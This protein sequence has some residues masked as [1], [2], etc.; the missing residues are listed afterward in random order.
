MPEHK[1]YL[2]PF[3]GSGAVFFNKEPVKVEII[4]DIDGDVV[5]LFR[6]I[7]DKPMELARGLQWTPYSREEYMD[8]HLKV[9]DDI[10]RARRFLVRCWQ[11]IRV[12]TVYFR[13]EV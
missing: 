12:K 1:T 5:N 7:R 11:S 8:S 10:E 6:V 13:V 9:K 3:F 2:E 4:N